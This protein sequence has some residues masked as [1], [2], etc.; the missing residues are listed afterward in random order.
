VLCALLVGAGGCGQA[1][2]VDTGGPTPT[3]TPTTTPMP[4]PTPPPVTE[5]VGFDVELPQIV[6]AIEMYWTETLPQVAGIPYEPLSGVHA[7]DPDEPSTW[8]T[9]G[10][11]PLGPALNAY[12][13]YPDDFLAYDEE[14][15]EEIYATTGD[16]AVG[17][18][19]AHEWGHAIQDQLVINGTSWLMEQ[20]ADCFAGAWLSW[21]ND[22]GA[23]EVGDIEETAEILAAIADPRP[24]RHKAEDGHGDEQE[25]IDAFLLGFE[26]GAQACLGAGGA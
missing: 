9:C 18:M 26:H 12:Y 24:D 23:L 15:A 3:P 1:A 4:T 10:G 11:E 20:Q 25:R 8:P 2:V 21:M 19:I 22:A 13:C 6:E 17:A 14:F 5:D 7:Y 16:A